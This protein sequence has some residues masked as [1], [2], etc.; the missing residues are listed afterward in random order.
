MPVRR[1]DLRRFLEGHRIAAARHRAET[2]RRLAFLTIDQ[3]REE[4]DS[5]CR[6]WEASGAR[7]GGAT[8]DR[9]A[10][11]ERIALRRRLSRFERAW[12]EYGPAK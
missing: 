11:A 9:R 1:E 3:A 12:A 4:Y 7:A 2:L 10:I 6:V 8:V 5:L